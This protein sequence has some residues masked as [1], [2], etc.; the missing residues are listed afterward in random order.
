M[1]KGFTLL[2]LLFVMVVIS[3]L[4]IS[5]YFTTMNALQK[6]KK[7]N[8]IN[9]SKSIIR[10]SDKLFSAQGLNDRIVT[11]IS[12]D[13]GVDHVALNNLSVD[14][15]VKLDETGKLKSFKMSNQKYY[16]EGTKS[17]ELK[18][19]NVKY[20]QFNNFSCDYEFSEDDLLEEKILNMDINGKTLKYIKTA[21]YCFIGAMVLYLL[22]RSKN[23]R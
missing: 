15:C 5:A 20:G 12:S 4:A 2:E 19:D 21:S 13:E 8:F 3:L 6:A 23:A 10:E 9:D 18:S 14:Y 16:I 22:F 11:I 7:S 1:K 17:E